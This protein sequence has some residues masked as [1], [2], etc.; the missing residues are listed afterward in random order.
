[1]EKT[2]S[3]L[4][5]LIEESKKAHEKSLDES[6]SEDEADAAYSDYWS[7]LTKIADILVE[8]IKVDEKTAIRMAAHKADQILDLV[9]RAA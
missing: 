3:E 7:Y 9:K 8:L 4:K 5:T 2:I 1:M 6:L